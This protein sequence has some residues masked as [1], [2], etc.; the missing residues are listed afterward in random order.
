[1][2]PVVVPDGGWLS[3]V[4]GSSGGGT[5]GQHQD[6][7]AGSGTV[8]DVVGVGASRNGPLAAL[9]Q[10]EKRQLQEELTRLDAPRGH[11]HPDDIG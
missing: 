11:T 6:R 4:W 8:M 7:E 3:W 5:A 1:M 9:T 10:D 2:R